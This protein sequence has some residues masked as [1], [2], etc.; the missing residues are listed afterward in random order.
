MVLSLD[1]YREKGRQGIILK[2][3]RQLLFHSFTLKG[4]G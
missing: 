2:K 3:T 4:N 1:E